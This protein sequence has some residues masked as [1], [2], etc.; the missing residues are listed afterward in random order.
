MFSC[1]Q[2][3]WQLVVFIS[4]LS[5]IY[6]ITDTHKGYKW[7]DKLTK[8]QA[9]AF[10]GSLRTLISS[11]S[12]TT[13]SFL[14][15]RGWRC[16]LT[17]VPWS[18]P[19]PPPGGYMTYRVRPVKFNCKQIR[20]ELFAKLTTHSYTLQCVTSQFP[21]EKILCKTIQTLWARRNCRQQHVPE[22][23]IA[24]DGGRCEQKVW[25]VFWLDE[26]WWKKL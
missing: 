21:A 10:G 3:Q 22:C 2:Y 11:D 8:G 13:F 18:P 23:R 1:K 25:V 19:A 26:K 12:W 7:P 9:S 20:W 14:S 24:T 16:L 6:V 15:P 4:L 5:L 17:P